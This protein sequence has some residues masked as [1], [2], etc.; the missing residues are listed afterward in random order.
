MKLIVIIG[1]ILDDNSF[2][3]CSGVMYSFDIKSCQLSA[4]I[5][6][7]ELVLINHLKDDKRFFF[8]IETKATS[9]KGRS[10]DLWIC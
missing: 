8:M 2:N 10:I 3:I 6:E 9:S 7:L 5:I 1:L 4:E